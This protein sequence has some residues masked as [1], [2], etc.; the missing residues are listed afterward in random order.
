M[1]TSKFNFEWHDEL[2]VSACNIPYWN[3][4]AQIWE[5]I[6]GNWHSMEEMKLESLQKTLKVLIEVSKL[7][8]DRQW[9]IAQEAFGFLKSIIAFPKPNHRDITSR[10]WQLIF[11]LVAGNTE[12]Q[13][14]IWKECHGLLL[15]YLRKDFPYKDTCR[16]IVYN[17]HSIGRQGRNEATTM[18]NI[19]LHSF[20]NERVKAKAPLKEQGLTTFLEHFIIYE[21]NFSIMYLNIT[22]CEKLALLQFTIDYL[23]R[24]Y[25]DGQKGIPISVEHLFS[26]CNDFISKCQQNL[27]C[28]S[29]EDLQ[30]IFLLFKVIAIVSNEK[31]YSLDQFDFELLRNVV[32]LLTFIRYNADVA[33]EAFSTINMLK[34]ALLMTISNLVKTNNSHKEMAKDSGIIEELV[35]LIEAEGGDIFLYRYT[36]YALMDLC[37]GNPNMEYLSGIVTQ[38]EHKASPVLLKLAREIQWN[39]SP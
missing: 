19:L 13:K 5:S 28:P 36:I 14:K 2:L 32:Q 16:L 23:E 24:K 33:V 17:I 35:N 15:K 1:A 12:N 39:T 31:Y 9:I 6:D 7:G 30:S 18:L 34:H 10:A 22:G 8:K 21:K 11:N 27:G 20:Y 3:K 26:M 29:S 38:R 4:A 37:K 25:A